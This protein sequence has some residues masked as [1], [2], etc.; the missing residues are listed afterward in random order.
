VSESEAQKNKEIRE[1]CIR[2]LT[3][4]EHSQRE[5][6]NKLSAK[7]FDPSDLQTVI[8]VLAE[9]GWQSNPR[10]AESYARYRIKKGYGPIKIAFELQ[11][12]GIEDTHVDPVALDLADSWDDIIDSV[13]LKKFTDDKDLVNKEW[14]KRTRFLQQRGFNHEMISQLFKR[15]NIQLHYA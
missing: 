14:L 12:R 2:L 5:L 6:L 8:D 4:R 13:Y 11:Q 10:F 15:L 3:R 9:Q 1:A 7:G